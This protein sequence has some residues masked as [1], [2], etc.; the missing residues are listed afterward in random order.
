VL[1]L[2]RCNQLPAERIKTWLGIQVL[3]ISF[4]PSFSKHQSFFVAKLSSFFGHSI[5][6]SPRNMSCP[7][8][9]VGSPI[10]H[11]HSPHISG[12]RSPSPI[13]SPHALS[14]SSTPLT[15]CGG[16][17]PFHHQRQTTVN[18][19]H[20]GIGSSRS[21]GSGGNFYTNSFFQEP[22]RQQDR[23]RSSPRTPPHVFWDNNGS[24]QP[25]YNWNK[26]NQPV[27]SDHVSQQLLSEHLKLKSLDLRPGFSTPGSTNRGP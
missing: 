15:G 22:S 10:F 9:P 25:G 5:S 1:R 6:Q 23:S 3:A 2:G 14:G 27:L 19:L 4:L 17:I 11:S 12:R 18:F 21:P 16:A 26:D 7:I 13:S 8:S 24:I 20:E